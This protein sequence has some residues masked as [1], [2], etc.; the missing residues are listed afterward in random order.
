[1]PLHLAN[2][3]S[4]IIFCY[5]IGEYFN[6]FLPSKLCYLKDASSL[7]KRMQRR[8]LNGYARPVHKSLCKMPS[9]SSLHRS[10]INIARL[11]AESLEEV[12]RQF[13]VVWNSCF[14]SALMGLR[15]IQIDT[16]WRKL[17][18]SSF[19]W[20]L[21]GKVLKTKTF[22]FR[23][24][25]RNFPRSR[26]LD[27]HKFPLTHGA[28]LIRCMQADQVCSRF[29]TSTR[30]EQMIKQFLKKNYYYY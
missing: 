9:E 27:W 1:M 5:C 18:E 23:I 6:R 10:S 29:K 15:I 7:E 21:T 19:D 17:S 4:N 26:Q 24:F 30:S 11:Q 16:N 14:A 20:N 3:F 12:R 22:Q 28:S 25:H 2:D 8:C 13:K